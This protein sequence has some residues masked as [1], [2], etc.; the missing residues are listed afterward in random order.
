MLTCVISGICLFTLPLAGEVRGCLDMSLCHLWRWS[1]HSWAAWLWG[2]EQDL[3]TTLSVWG[4][5]WLGWCYTYRNLG[6]WCEGFD[7]ALSSP[8]PPLRLSL[9]T[10]PIPGAWNSTFGCECHWAHKPFAIK[11]VKC[12]LS[13]GQLGHSTPAPYRAHEMCSVTVCWVALMCYIW[14]FD[15]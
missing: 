11:K 15:R 9:L 12:M 4:V 10:W 5:G 6:E 7:K 14:Q 3:M 13:C 2:S 8:P 1:S